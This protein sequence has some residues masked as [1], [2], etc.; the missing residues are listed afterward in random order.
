MADNDNYDGEYHFVDQ[1]TEHSGSEDYNKS[2]DEGSP[3]FSE[4]MDVE[5]ANTAKK[6]VMRNALMVVSVIIVALVLYPLIHSMM[7]GKKDESAIISAPSTSAMKAAVAPITVAMPESTAVVNPS[8]DI[9][10]KLS[11]L[12]SNQQDMKAE[13]ANT[14]N[15]LSGINNNINTMMTKVTELNNTIAHF[16]AKVDEQA[17]KIERLTAEARAIKKVHAPRKMQPKNAVPVLQY[18]IQAVIPGRAWLIA[19]NGSTLTVREGTVIPGFGMVKLI[20][21]RQG[22]VLTSSGRAIRFSQEDS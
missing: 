15:E 10:Q 2:T 4:N 9:N 3:I 16:T 18:Y 12:E 19:T 14:S 6:N 1:D 7:S 20:D 13:F 11:M 21:A 22:R 8:D 5:R 17:E